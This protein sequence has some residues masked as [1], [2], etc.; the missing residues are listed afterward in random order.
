MTGISGMLGMKCNCIVKL[1]QVILNYDKGFWRDRFLFR[2]LFLFSVVLENLLGEE[3]GLACRLVIDG[4]QTRENL[5]YGWI[6]NPN[7]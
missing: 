2:I 7:K 3:M 6:T 1:K 5:I 4:M